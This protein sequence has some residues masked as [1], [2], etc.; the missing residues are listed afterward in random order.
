VEVGAHTLEVQ[1][2]WGNFI[3]TNRLH[4][5]TSKLGLFNHVIC[6]ERSF[7]SGVAWIPSQIISLN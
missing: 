6:F 2:A 7:N 3:T 5:N 4:L 1:V